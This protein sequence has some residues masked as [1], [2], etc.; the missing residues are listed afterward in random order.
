MPF[1]LVPQMNQSWA[2]ISGTPPPWESYFG[3]V[4]GFTIQGLGTIGIQGLGTIGIN[5]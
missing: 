1:T 2:W 5:L 3:N 4:R